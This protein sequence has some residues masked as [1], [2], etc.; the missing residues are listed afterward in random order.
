MYPVS[1]V[2]AILDGETAITVMSQPM[3]EAE[4]SLTSSEIVGESPAR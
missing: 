4:T 2:V 3:R 1:L